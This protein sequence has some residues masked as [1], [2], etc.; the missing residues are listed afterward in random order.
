MDILSLSLLSIGLAADAFSVSVTSG[1]LIQ[2]IKIH[3]VLIIALAFGIFQTLMFFLGG[4][5]GFTVRP[6]IGGVQHWIAFILLSAIGGKMIYESFKTEDEENETS[7]NPTEI[8][9]LLGLAIATSID[10]LAA[11]LGLISL[12]DSLLFS[13]IVIG[14]VTF[15]LSACG[16][17]LG[18]L[19]GRHLDFKAE[20]IGGFV[21][22]A[23]GLRTLWEHF[24]I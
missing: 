17:L 12:D 23:L 10:A 8:Y 18:N 24:L 14:A 9:T 15:A 6:W 21:L 20:I 5:M 3:K 19:I 2:R 16:V 11:G 13:A 7:F 22:I 1:L 4:F